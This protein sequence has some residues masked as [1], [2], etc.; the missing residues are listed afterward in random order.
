MPHVI[1]RSQMRR[2]IS[3]GQF[4]LAMVTGVHPYRRMLDLPGSKV[5]SGC[6]GVVSIEPKLLVVIP[7]PAAIQRVLQQGGGPEGSEMKRQNAEKGS[8]NP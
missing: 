8:G 7:M 5:F 1:I 3:S 4:R 6:I 2:I